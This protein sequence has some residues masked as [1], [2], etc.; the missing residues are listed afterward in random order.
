MF[1]DRRF[2]LEGSYAGGS[3]AFCGT[4][5]LNLTFLALCFGARGCGG[6]VDGLILGRAVRLSW[7]QKVRRKLFSV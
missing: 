3:N 6:F 7:R 4:P 2:L 1:N 5:L